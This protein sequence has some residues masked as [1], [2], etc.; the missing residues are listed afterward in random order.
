MSGRPVFTIEDDEG[1]ILWSGV[2]EFK[3]EVKL[4]ELIENGYDVYLNTLPP[5]SGDEEAY[6]RFVK[7]FDSKS[8]K[9]I[10]EMIDER[11]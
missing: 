4:C 2:D 3:A 1:Q 11:E 9:K 5:M 6:W 7:A 10:S 8:S